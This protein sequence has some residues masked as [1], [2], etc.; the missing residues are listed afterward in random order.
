MYGARRRNRTTDTGIFN[1]LLY[2]LSYPGFLC[3][4]WGVLKEARIKPA[5][6]AG[7]KPLNELVGWWHVAFD[8]VGFCVAEELVHLLAKV[9]AGGHV[10]EV[11]LFFVDEHGLVVEPFLPRLYGD[12]FE[13]VLAFGAG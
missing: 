2:R 11:E 12:V 8:G 7:V 1:P 4:R 3:Y 5:R 13:D 10:H 9:A 6:W